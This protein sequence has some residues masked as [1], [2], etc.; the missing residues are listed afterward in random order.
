MGWLE[1]HGVGEWL[2]GWVV[3]E[4]MGWVGMWWCGWWWGGWLD[5]SWGGCIYSPTHEV[6]ILKYLI[7]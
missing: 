7:L 4:F 5:S 1:V 3:G 2:V 6:T